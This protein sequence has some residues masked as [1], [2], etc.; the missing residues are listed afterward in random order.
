MRRFTPPTDHRAQKAAERPVIVR[1]I[2]KEAV[3]VRT[4]LVGLLSHFVEL[5]VFFAAAA[6]LGAGLM[7]LR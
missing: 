3:M 6:A 5:S 1:S 2:R 7:I 4:R